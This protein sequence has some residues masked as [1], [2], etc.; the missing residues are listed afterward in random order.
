MAVLKNKTIKDMSDKEKEE[1]LK[2]LNKELEK[3][4][5][6]KLKQKMKFVVPL[7]MIVSLLLVASS[8]TDISLADDPDTSF[9]EYND[10][11][12]CLKQTLL[13]VPLVRYRH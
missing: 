5:M 9:P 12:E 11:R 2:E 8:A 7:V 10:I 6:M 4:N 13:F 3:T 1:K